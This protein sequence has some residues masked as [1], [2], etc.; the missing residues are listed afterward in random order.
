MK[1][2]LVAL[3]FAFGISF[4]AVGQTR[5]RASS[6]TQSPA[7]RMEIGPQA[8]WKPLEGKWE[9][10]QEKCNLGQGKI[11][12]SCIASRMRKEGASPEAVEFTRLMKGEVYL[13]SFREMGKVDIAEVTRPLLNDPIVTDS[14][15]VNGS[16]KIVELWGKAKNIDITRDRNYSA[17]VRRFPNLELWPMHGFETMQ[18]LPQGGQRFIFN[19]T[20]LNGCHAC[21]PA[22]SAQIA[23]DFDESGRFLRTSLVRLIQ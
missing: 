2:I 4:I 6:S 21:E 7:R 22:G 5:S 8:V 15:L 23:F 12:V 13:S 17:L 9:A 16:Q 11:S 20:L 3:V 18:R 1:S 14:I 10:I 19:F